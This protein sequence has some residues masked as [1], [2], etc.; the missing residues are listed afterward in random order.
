MG[1][2]FRPMAACF[3]TLSAAAQVNVL[4]YKNDNAR[5][6]QNLNEPLLSPANV[7]AATFGRR[8]SHGVDGYIYGE[9]LY[10]DRPIVVARLPRY[11][12]EAGAA[13]KPR[14]SWVWA[15]GYALT[16]N[17]KAGRPTIWAC[18]NCMFMSF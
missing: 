6:G 8:F 16:D 17:Q 7:S 14:T 15:L 1:S 18:K 5:T 10:D 4:T 9:P 12:T 11:H 13:K 2:R 3:F